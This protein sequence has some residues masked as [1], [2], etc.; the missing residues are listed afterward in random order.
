MACTTRTRLPIRSSP[1][2]QNMSIAAT[3]IRAQPC[4]AGTGG[5]TDSLY[6]NAAADEADLGD[7]LGGDMGGDGGDWT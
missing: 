6:Q 5:I 1:S 3:E 7:D 4:E 2:D